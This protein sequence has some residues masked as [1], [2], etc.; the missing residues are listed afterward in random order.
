MGS[1]ARNPE[2]ERLTQRQT[3]AFAKNTPYHSLELPDGR[4][5]PGI[6]P[7]ENLRAR[8]NAFRFRP[9]SEANGF[10]I[11][12]PH[13]DGTALNWNGGEPHVVAIDCVEFEEFVAAKRLLNSKVEYLVLDVD[14]ISPRNLGTFDYVIFFGV[15]YHLRH[16]LLAL[17]KVC[18]LTR[19]AA[20]V[21][22]FVIDTLAKMDGPYLEFYET[23]ELG[24]QIDNWFGPTRDCLVATL[25]LGGI[26]LGSISCTWMTAAPE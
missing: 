10:W 21:E 1:A 3:A 24:G 15:L 7:V 22:S 12:A 6:I 25:P 11:S 26:R 2:F 14:E 23:T 17:E 13:R 19:E 20:F 5:I 16:P 9:I 4:V 18:S 8:L